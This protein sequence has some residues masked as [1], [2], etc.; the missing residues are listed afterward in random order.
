[1]RRRD[2]IRIVAGSA[3][4][5][6]AAKAQPSNKPVIGFLSARSAKE[7]A[8]LVDAFRKG[9]A[10]H[11]LVEGQNVIIEFSWA[12]G[13]YE[14]LPAQAN[15]LLTRQPAVL[16]SAGGDMSAKAASAATKT[17]PIV[18]IF[19]GDCNALANPK[20]REAAPASCRDRFACEQSESQ[21]RMRF[22]IL[23]SAIVSA[24]LPSVF[25]SCG[26]SA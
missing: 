23:A 17:T 12:D 26:C 16:I 14:R 15:H 5:P 3:A 24:A 11:G 4:W 20:T 1:M 21:L 9:L 2:F 8:H 19:I 7:S 22:A 6:L 25:T 18:A 13:N 10:E